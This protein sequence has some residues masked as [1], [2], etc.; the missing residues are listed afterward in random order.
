M[1]RAS[2]IA[3]SIVSNPAQLLDEPGALTAIDPH[4]ACDALAGFPAQCRAAVGIE[5]T[6]LPQPMK[7][8]RL[9]VIAGM[10]G[11]AAAGDIIVGCAASHLEVPVVVHRGY[12]LPSIAQDDALVVAVSYSGNTA[13]VLSAA[14]TAL[15]RRIPLIAITSGGALGALATQ[16]G[17]GC[18][19]VPAGLMPRMALGYLFFPLARVLR[20]LDLEVVTPDEIA[21]ALAE[22]ETL[23]QV[24]RPE[25]PSADN[26]AKRVALAIEQRWPAV[27][28]GPLTGP[29]AYRW[30]TDFEE[31]AKSF[32]LAGALP[33]MNHNTI[34]AWRAPLARDLQLVLLRDPHEAPEIRRRFELLEEMVRAVAG[35]VTTCRARGRAPLA[36]LLTLTYLGQWVSYY[37]AI[38]RHVDPWSVPRL[39]EVKRRLMGD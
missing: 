14:E 38:L 21:E 2:C 8:P 20:A 34:E 13:E 7:R 27:Y 4:R 12:T 3:T 6:L 36:R 28:G 11:S 23:G 30:K 32:A 31:N 26:E 25:C 19:E 37:L 10:G 5:P 29:V 15:A 35:G 16:R 22:L 33:E 24:L 39:D 9:V 1:R 17:A 18:V